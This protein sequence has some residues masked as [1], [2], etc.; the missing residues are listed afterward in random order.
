MPGSV[1]LG[2]SASINTKEP[3]PFF[4]F[5][6]H[7][8]VIGITCLL[9]Y[10][11]QI[12][13]QNG[14]LSAQSCCSSRWADVNIKPP[15]SSG[16]R[17]TLICIILPPDVPIKRLRVWCTLFHQSL[18]TRRTGSFPRFLPKPDSCVFLITRREWYQRNKASVITISC[19]N[20]TP[21]F[22]LFFCPF[23]PQAQ[24]PWGPCLH[25]EKSRSPLFCLF[26]ALIKRGVGCFFHSLE[27]ATSCQMTSD[28]LI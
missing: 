23:C 6:L 7:Y 27:T 15:E 20:Q 16:E 10:G 4:P 19:S 11:D 24:S 28:A 13:H 18:S 22:V 3:E 2:D 14:G 21:S 8:N 1:G 26:D 17:G 25:V 5:G 12:N 9:H